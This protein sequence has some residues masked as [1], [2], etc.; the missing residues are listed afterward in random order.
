MILNRIIGNCSKCQAINS[1]GILYISNNS[2]LYGCK[3]CK[4]THLCKLPDLRNKIIYLD[5]FFLSKVFRKSD[6]DFLSIAEKLKR[7]AHYQ[8]LVCPYSTIHE[9]ETHQWKPEKRGE[10]FK[11]IKRFSRGHD[12]IP[13]Y[14][15]EMTQ[16][17]RSYKAFLKGDSPQIELIERD[18]LADDVHHWDDY[19]WIDVGRYVEDIELIRNLKNEVANGFVDAVD[20]WKNKNLSFDEILIQEVRAWKDNIINSF[21]KS[22]PKVLSDPSAFLDQP[23]ISEYFLRLSMIKEAGQT[24]DERMGKVMQFLQSDYIRHIPFVDIFSSIHALL[25]YKVQQSQFP[26]TTEKIKETVSG[27]YYDAKFIS[28]YAPYCDA[29][30]VDNS[31]YQWLIDEKIDIESKYV[32]KVF[33]KAILEDFR[34][35]LDGIERD[36]SVE[37][38]R[39]VDEIY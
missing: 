32:V 29:I 34:E 12:F 2:I 9:S 13:D 4:T 39:I 21:L 33:S 5:Q 8:A 20:G 37:Q 38:K 35:Y 7:L 25:R 24:P 30:F 18:A 28:V 31:M 1:Y 36:I 16:L 27:L 15:V 26:T 11:F 14:D 10:L 23:I 3:S 19:I 6:S 17:Q 22:A